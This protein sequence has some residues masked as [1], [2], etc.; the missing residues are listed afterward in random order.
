MESPS[1]SSSQAAYRAA[2]SRS[3]LCDGLHTPSVE[4]AMDGGQA[5]PYLPLHDQTTSHRPD[6]PRAARRRLPRRGRCGH[7]H[8]RPHRSHD[9]E[10]A[11]RSTARRSASNSSL[12]GDLHGRPDRGGSAAQVRGDL[13]GQRDDDVVE[14][15]LRRPDGSN[16]SYALRVVRRSGTQFDERRHEPQRRSW[17]TTNDLLRG[18]FTVSIAVKAGDQ[19]GL[20]VLGGSATSAD[21]VTSVPTTRPVGRVRRSTAADEPSTTRTLTDGGP[22][23]APDFTF[24]RTADPGARATDPDGHA[25]RGASQA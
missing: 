23:R 22:A 14:L 2:E 15:P 5:G 18:P 10:P 12:C 8:D 13:T 4:Y 6:R 16:D 20:R 7:D 3:T 1:S 9:R 21:Q 25:G 19:L 24:T 17:P 11:H